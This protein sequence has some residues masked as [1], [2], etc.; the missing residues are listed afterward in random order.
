MELLIV[1][2][3]QGLG[4][5][6]RKRSVAQDCNFTGLTNDRQ[7]MYTVFKILSHFKA[8]V[9][10]PGGIMYGRG[11]SEHTNCVAKW[12]HTFGDASD[13]KLIC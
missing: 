3:D 11:Y 5:T 12:R 2:G 10:S 9:A 7:V 6:E 13:A 4:S 1:L 8:C